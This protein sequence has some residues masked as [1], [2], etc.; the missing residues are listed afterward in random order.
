M[1]RGMR[2]E[3]STV[4]LTGATGGIGRTLARGL[5]A[6]KA[7]V[8]VTGR[9]AERLEALAGELGVR[10]VVA[11][12]SRRDDVRRLVSATGAVDVLIA[13]A[14]VAGDGRIGDV[15]EADI[16][17]AIEVN[18]AAPIRLANALVPL[19]RQRGRGHVVF[20]GSAGSRVT[21]PNSAIYNATKFGLRGFSLAL[22]QDLAGSGVGVS[23]IE[24]LF[25]GDVG[26]FADS[27]L[28]M[29]KGMRAGSSDDVLRAVLRAVRRNSAE[30]IVAPPDLRMGIALAAVAPELS[31]KAGRMLGVRFQSD[32]D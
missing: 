12:L 24:P 29:P 6:A 8:I 19:M 21:A 14:A 25:V 28:A 32:Q 3:G 13:N 4:L 31:A 10:C 18:L 16:D 20:L 11:D 15:A 30:V 5:V 7:N 17:D 22:R 1:T 9:N 27:G 26:M 2:I 23:I